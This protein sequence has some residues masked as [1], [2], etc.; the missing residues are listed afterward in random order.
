[1]RASCEP[2]HLRRTPG[3]TPSTRAPSPP[4]SRPRQATVNQWRRLNCPQFPSSVLFTSHFTMSGRGLI[5]TR[6]NLRH[7]AELATITFAIPPVV[8]ATPQTS[9]RSRS[10]WNPPWEVPQETCAAPSSPCGLICQV[11]LAQNLVPPLSFEGFARFAL[12]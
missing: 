5:V 6:H 2:L 1:M 3:P 10:P 9:R 4:R 7:S 11:L 8:C 12:D